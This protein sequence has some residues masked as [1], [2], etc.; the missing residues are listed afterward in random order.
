MQ[1]FPF[2]KINFIEKKKKTHQFTTITDCREHLVNMVAHAT[3][4]ELSN[5]KSH[6]STAF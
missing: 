4:Q 6:V 2:N 3:D 1:T 5:Y